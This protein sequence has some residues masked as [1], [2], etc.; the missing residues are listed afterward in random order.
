MLQRKMNR[1]L[2][3]RRPRTTNKNKALR[4][5][6]TILLYSF[7]TNPWISHWESMTNLMT[8]EYKLL[9]QETAWISTTEMKKESWIN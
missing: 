2:N 9:L 3:S 8:R 6:M 4:R 7:L 5:L 1:N